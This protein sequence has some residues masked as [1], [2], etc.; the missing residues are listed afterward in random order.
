MALWQRR[1]KVLDVPGHIRE[2]GTIVYLVM[3][4]EAQHVILALN[5]FDVLCHV[6]FY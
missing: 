2:P 3:D 1:R 6:G 4:L 5:G